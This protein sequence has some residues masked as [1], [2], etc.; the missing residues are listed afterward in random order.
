M[1]SFSRHAILNLSPDMHFRKKNCLSLL[2]YFISGNKRILLQI[3]F[4]LENWHRVSRS[5]LLWTLNHININVKCT[6]LDYYWYEI[7]MTTFYIQAVRSDFLR[8]IY[9][10]LCSCFKFHFLFWEVKFPPP[11]I[12]LLISITMYQMPSLCFA[13]YYWIQD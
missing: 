3:C 10:H 6:S 7:Y 8:W 4:D 13:V 1:N 2:N 5:L 9:W 12:K 11:H